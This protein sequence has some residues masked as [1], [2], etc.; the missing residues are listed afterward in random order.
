MYAAFLP[1]SQSAHAFALQV[2]GMMEKKFRGAAKTSALKMKVE[3]D[4]TVTCI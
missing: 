1:Y 2:H 3:Y 4:K